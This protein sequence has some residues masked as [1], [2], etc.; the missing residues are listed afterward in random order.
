MTNIRLFVLLAL[1]IIWTGVAS[2]QE[3][4]LGADLSYVNELEDC[5]A[6]YKN[7]IENEADPFELFSSE[8]TNL[9]R[10]RL[11]HD[12]QWTNYSNLADVK[13]SIARAKSEG[14]KVLLDFH[15]SDFW[16]DPGRQ[17]RPAA[18]E[19]IE[20]D[21]MLA[22]ELY[23][24]TYNTLV[25]LNKSGLLPEMVQIGNETN[26]NILIKRGTEDLSGES[27]G[28]YPIDWD[29]QAML[30]NRALD[31]VEDIE[32]EF[33]TEVK[34]VIH[35]ADPISA[36]SWF[37]NAHSNNL[38][39]YDIIGLS[40]YPQ[41]HN[42]G[43][44]EAGAYI[45]SL[46]S[47]FEKEVMI[48]ETGYPWTNNGQDQANN[49]LN[50]DSRLFTYS[51]NFSI[52]IQRDFLI[53][54]SW[55]VKENGGLGVI[56]WEPAWISSSCQT[57]WATGSHWENV[58]L[59]DF[60]GQLHSGADFLSYDY[61]QKP[62][63]LEDQEVTFKVDMSAIDTQNGVYVT[64]AFTG[65][66]WQFRPMTITS[67]SIYEYATTVPGRS[68]GAYIFYNDDQWSDS[69][70]ETV[71]E[72]CARLWGTH[73]EYWI[74][75]DE[76]EFYFSWGRCD[77]TP[78]EAVLGINDPKQI[79]LFPAMVRDE[80]TIQSL[81]EF[82]K[83]EIFDLKGMKHSAVVAADNTM[84]VAHLPDGLYLLRVSSEA[85]THILKFIKR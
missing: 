4:Y 49:V 15:Y 54:L 17:W 3:F 46:K 50:F 5:G 75:G 82:R 67:G 22:D 56:Y 39:S 55:L 35:I 37:Q 77:Q 80:L 69:Y 62:S 61:S 68:A 83:M 51:N 11:W 72:N 60:D 6:I 45:A 79:S 20:D 59:F 76:A 40:Y 23:N 7:R 26:G 9:V 63:A 2:A 16:A 21:S 58:A 44:R 41:W 85:N 64:G 52:E 53:E 19:S 30:F 18:W 34:T 33:D 43:V 74:Q 84:N 42:L 36:I 57:Y 32:T 71:P 66:D 10:L 27:P 81:V 14:M 24:Y 38:D 70:R 1:E 25:E 12:P 73:R 78:N 28:L 31:A 47:Q 8:G 13:G 48:V 65:D 29:R